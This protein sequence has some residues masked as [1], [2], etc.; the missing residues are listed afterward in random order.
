NLARGDAYQGGNYNPSGYA[1]SFDKMYRYLYGGVNRTNYVIDN[2]TA[3]LP[4]ASPSSV[5]NL[6]AII[7]EARLL[8]GMVY[9]RLISMWGDVPYISNIV[10]DNS[11]VE[12]I[13]RMPIAQVKDSIMADFTY[14]F[15]KLPVKAKEVGR[16]AK[17]DRK[18]TRLNSSHVN[19]SYA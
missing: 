12:N 14:A 6:E 8:R 15:E 13:T 7:G 3:M 9:F 2:V 11:E 16:A 10:Y 19:S 17:P 1:G 4:T 18:R 5:E